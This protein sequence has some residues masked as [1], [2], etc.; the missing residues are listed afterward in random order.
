MR[1]LFLLATATIAWAIT[2]VAAASQ[3]AAELYERGVAARQDQRFEDA[4]VA[5][6]RALALEPANADT[7]VQLGFARLGAGD[8]MGARQAFENALLLA[9][10][11]SDAAFGLAQVEFR[12]GDRA[13]ATA[14][15]DPL[16]AAD[17]NNSEYIA[18]QAS[19]ASSV[20]AGF[21]RW[22][23]DV[24]SEVS[25][26]SGGRSSWT[27]SNIALTY[28]FNDRTSVAGRLRHA[29]RS[30]A[31]DWQ[32]E[33]RID[34]RI[35]DRIGVY[36]LTAATP[37][38][39][40]LARSSF[41]GGIG[42][43]V[44]DESPISG[45][46]IFGVDGRYDVFATTDVWTLSPHLQIFAFNERLGLTARWFHAE[47]DSGTVA[48][49]YSVR[50]AWTAT[51][52][53]RFFAGYADAP[54]ISDGQLDETR[55]AFGGLSVDVSDSVTLSGSYSHERRESFDRNTIGVGVSLRF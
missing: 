1:S 29:S 27:D 54:E 22:R 52:R 15:I 26:L 24:G 36:G 49:G 30:Q 51:D 4:V 33:A 8:S 5:L 3:S 34:H 12:E 44:L 45:P 28:R 18:L 2:V 48:D 37:D 43:R 6:E 38:A 25:D 19:I 11:Y 13:A 55:T 41:G 39:E 32:A 17:P 10:D 21:K 23:L 20:A 16:V 47:D 35:N 40:F 42:V 7:L 14:L 46:L 9:P 31:S 53:L 50:A